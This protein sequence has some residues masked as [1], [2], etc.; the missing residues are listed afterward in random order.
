MGEIMKQ[1]IGFVVG[2]IV[3]A[4]IVA[5][6]IA[7]S[8]MAQDKAGNAADTRKILAENAKVVALLS[9]FKPGVKNENPQSSSLRVVRALKGGTMERTYADGKKEKIVWKTGDVRILEAGPAFTNVNVGKTDVQLYT[10][11]L[12]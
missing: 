10:V 7:N 9:T 1:L 6:G 12:K 5:G 11:M 4:F 3:P 2:I 8:A